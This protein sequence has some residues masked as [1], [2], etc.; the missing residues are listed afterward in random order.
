M[1]VVQKAGYAPPRGSNEPDGRRR[2]SVK[3]REAILDALF[4]LIEAGDLRPSAQRVADEAGV[5]IRSVFRHFDDMDGL[6]AEMNVRLR[7]RFLPMLG[8]VDPDLPLEERLKE[9]VACRC[10][11]FEGMAPFKRASNLFRPSSEFLTAEHNQTVLDLRERMIGALPEVRDF[12]AARLAALEL[13]I[14][15]EAWDRLRA[16]QGLGTRQTRSVMEFMAMSVLRGA[17]AGKQKGA[18]G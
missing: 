2:R 5:G 15:F 16:E 14:S 18:G 7:E 13:A 10:R 11:C 6:Y 3:S 8:P 9:I 12:G 4:R 17:L 1:A